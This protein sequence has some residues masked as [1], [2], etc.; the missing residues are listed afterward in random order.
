MYLHHLAGMVLL[1]IA[2]QSVSAGVPSP[3]NR[4]WMP[5]TWQA[6]ATDQQTPGTREAPLPADWH[7]LGPF[8][9]DVDAVAASPTTSGLVLAGLAPTTGS[10]TL[11]RSTDGGDTWSEV[12]S[13]SG[14]SVYDIE[15]A[16]DGTAY[17][18]TMD[19][20]WKSVDDGQTWT[21]MNLGIG[22]ND[23]TYE[24]EIDPADMNTIWAGVADALGNQ[25]ENVLVSHDAGVTWTDKTPP[26]GSPMSCTGIAVAPTDS[27]RVVACFAGAFGGGQVWFSSDGGSTWV[28]RSA[29]L[30]GNPMFQVVDNGSRTLIC[31]GQNF[32]S[33]LFGVYLSM[34][35]GQTW[36]ELSDASWVSKAVNDITVD[37]N[38]ENIILAATDGKGIFRSTDGG[39]TWAFEVGGTTGL[40]VRS[41]KFS[42]GSSDTIYLGNGST[43]VYRSTD[44]GTSF[45]QT[46]VGIGALNVVD[47]AANSLDTDELA[48]AFQGLNDGGVYTSTDG[49][50]SWELASLPATRYNTVAFAPDG[51]LYAISDGPTTVAPEGLYRR[52]P[53]NTWTSIGPDQGNL[54]E[55]ELFALTFDPDDPDLIMTGGSDFGVAGNEATIWR[56]V[57]MGATWTKVYEATDDFEDVKD[58][59]LTDTS[60][61]AGYIDTGT[62][63]SGGV[64]RS[65]D[66]GNNW[67]ESSSGLLFGMQIVDLQVAGPV[68]YLADQN[69]SGGGLF[70]SS[71]D[72]L[73]WS[74]SGFTSPL[75]AVTVDPGD[76]ANVFVLQRATPWV[77][78]SVDSGAT[79]TPYGTGLNAGFAETMVYARGGCDALLIAST[80]GSWGTSVH[81]LPGDLDGDGDVDQSDLGIL[82][83]SYLLN[84]GGDIDGDGDTDQSD[85]GILL[86]NYL[87]SC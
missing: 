4:G 86:S 2:V 32:G 73:S 76:L 8:G 38:D 64:L 34:N 30:P 48:I 47:I 57:D 71:D 6:A 59:V 54:F 21:A 55:S 31:G 84:D 66:N 79:F 20:V 56:S 83:A 26:M 50:V 45:T 17:I 51:T 53:D 16:S 74:Q 27:N 63:H 75:K 3:D 1:G 44:G 9:G 7:A 58:I 37:P 23:Q 81:A 18:G 11:Y 28:N 43:A 62:E 40:T 65:T 10:G 80:T 52:N 85:L 25:P 35:D 29:G 24:I 82:L 36:T 70:V 78:S 14:L 12:A 33:Q 49:G 61:L 19:G 60:M 72:G 5:V 67:T 39:T 68:V 46:S 69:T 42:P 13:L 15:F 41:V 87:M 22:V 77:Y